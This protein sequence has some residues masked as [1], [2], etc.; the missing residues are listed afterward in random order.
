MQSRGEKYSP[1]A[2]V[3]SAAA[4]WEEITNNASERRLRPSGDDVDDLYDEAVEVVRRLKKASVSL[5]QRQLRIGY[6]RAARLIDVME[7]RGI[8]GPAQS[9][10]KPRK[11]VGYSDDDFDLNDDGDDEDYADDEDFEDEDDES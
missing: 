6:T 2:P 8:V 7:E 4:P 3:R 11:V 1:P 5:L 9:G 10:S